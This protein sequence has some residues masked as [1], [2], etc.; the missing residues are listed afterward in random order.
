MMRGKI[1]KICNI[2]F[3]T[4]FA[5]VSLFPLL[6][7]FYTSFSSK[8]SIE[9]IPPQFIKRDYTT[10]NYLNLFTHSN[11]F[12]WFFN[13]ILV[14]TI[15]TVLHLFFDSLAGYAFAKKRFPGRL[16]LFWVIIATMMIP[17][18]AIIVPLYLMMSKLRLIDNLLAVI[19][20]ALAGPFGVFLMKQYIEG[21]PRDLLD[22][23]R[24]DGCS[25]FDIYL[26]IILPLSKP[27]LGVLGIFTFITHWNAFLWPL[28]VLNSSKNYTLTVGLAT[29]QSKQILDYGLLMSGACIAAAP[30]IAVFFLF[31]RFLIRGIRIGAL[32]G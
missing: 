2:I 20:P 6:W 25:E 30:M 8:T 16:F 10:Q 18:Q 23:G 11:I 17:G 12:R 14:S 9:A 1:C 4:S 27:I 5:I 13:S 24:I 19:L 29:L 15:I 22:A 28:I 32:K 7:M 3:L 21:I 26:R 31:Q